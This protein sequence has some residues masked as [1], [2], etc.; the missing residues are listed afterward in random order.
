MLEV[1]PMNW[2][3]LEL[4]RKSGTGRKLTIGMTAALLTVHCNG[5]EYGSFGVKQVL[6]RT[7]HVTS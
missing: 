2:F 1:A 6:R 7:E 4:L 3:D 5:E